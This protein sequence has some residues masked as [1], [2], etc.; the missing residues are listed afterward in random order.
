MIT[1]EEVDATWVDT[2]VSTWTWYLSSL[3]RAGLTILDRTYAYVK[4]F[5]EAEA[6][7]PLWESVED[8]LGAPCGIAMLVEVDFSL[9]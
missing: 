7:S 4:E 5:R 2:I 3:Q 9:P 6:F 1:L 8:G